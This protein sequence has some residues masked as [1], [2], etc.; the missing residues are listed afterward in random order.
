MSDIKHPNRRQFHRIPIDLRA[1]LH[2]D[3]SSYDC[4][5]VDV[6][7]HGVLLADA[8]PQAAAAGRKV[9]VDIVIDQ[10][11]ETCIHMQG[12]IAHAEDGQLGVTCHQLDLESASQLRRL[13]ELNLADPDLLERELTAMIDAA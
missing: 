7:L 6:S 9:K 11:G 13:V 12:E 2:C 5:V 10:L 3:G 4:R 8:A 1:A